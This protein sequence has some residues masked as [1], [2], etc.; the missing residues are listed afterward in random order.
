MLIQ[1]RPESD[2]IADDLSHRW[3]CGNGH[4]V[5][6]WAWPKRCSAWLL[7]AATRAAWRV[8]PGCFPAV[9]PLKTFARKVQ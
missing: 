4:A 1:N 3:F 9:I 8:P 6:A 2:I 7:P 5:A